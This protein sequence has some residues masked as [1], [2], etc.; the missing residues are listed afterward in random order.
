MADRSS[1]MV[2]N[3]ERVHPAKTS[4]TVSA[5]VDMELLKSCLI[6][7]ALFC[8]GYAQISFGQNTRNLQQ[9]S[10]Q[11]KLGLRLV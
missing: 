6:L 9:R 4:V 1:R 7:S 10:N 11:S 8:V 2:W 5:L 3:E